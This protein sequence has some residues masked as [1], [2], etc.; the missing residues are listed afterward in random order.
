MPKKVQPTIKVTRE[1]TKSQVINIMGHNII[2]KRRGKYWI[3]LTIVSILWLVFALSVFTLN[4]V[5]GIIAILPAIVIW[6]A[7]EYSAKETGKK[8]YEFIKD[9]PQPVAV[10]EYL[11]NKE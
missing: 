7:Y 5:V 4:T 1:W 3:G 9:K 8:F 10:D 6:L 2:N 11:V